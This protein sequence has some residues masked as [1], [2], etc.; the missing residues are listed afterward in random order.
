MYQHVKQMADFPP[1]AVD[2][3][4]EIRIFG[5]VWV[6]LDE[7]H[8]DGSWSVQYHS[9]EPDWNANRFRAAITGSAGLFCVESDT[10]VNEVRGNH[11]R[12]ALPSDPHRDY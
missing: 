4:V 7:R 6:G 8:A 1:Q 5:G 9:G 11:R 10:E 12:A 2:A 3:D